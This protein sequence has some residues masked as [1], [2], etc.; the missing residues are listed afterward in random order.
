VKNRFRVIYSRPAQRE[1]ESLEIDTALRIAEDIK[2]YLEISPLPF[3][4]S[5]IKKLTGFHPP[6]YRL[7]SGNFRAYYRIISSDVVVLAITH[8]KDSEKALKRLKKPS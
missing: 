4:K 8:K 1:I 6:L 7:R 3:G 5:R 2:N